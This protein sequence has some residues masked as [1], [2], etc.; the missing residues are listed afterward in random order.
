MRTFVLR[1]LLALV[2]LLLA[3]TFI[4]QS[5]LVLSPGSYLDTLLDNKHALTPQLVDLLKHQYHLESNNVFTRYWYWLWQS[6]R[7]NFGYSF[8]YTLPVWSL[9]WQ[10]TFNTLLLSMA[11][12]AI[13][14]GVAVPLGTLAAVKRDTWVDRISGVVSY[15]G[16]SI[17]TVFFSLLMLLFAVKTGWFPTGGM[18]DQVHWDDFT[19]IQKL[20]DTLWHLALPSIVLGTVGLGQYARQMRAEMIETLGQDYIRTAKAKGLG[21]FRIVV[22]HALGNALNPLISLFGFSLAYLLA[23]AILTETV[24]SWPGLGRLT[25]EA[26]RYKD[27]PLVMASVVLLTVMLVAGALVSDLLLALIDPRI[28]LDGQ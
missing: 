26:L 7:G 13:S 1:R 4:T 20:G 27:E 23:G 12:L 8:H 24:F 3:V 17:P 14:W 2:P 10:R 28:R 15:F 18:H 21:T 11:A 16:L 22:N 19:P 6:L 25:F 9:I 5:L